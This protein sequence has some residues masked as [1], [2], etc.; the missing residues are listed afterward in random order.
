MKKTLALQIIL[1]NFI[2]SIDYETEIQPIFNSN[3]ISC[4]SYG[5]NSINNH[6]LMLTSYSGLMAGG[7]SGDVIVPGDSTNSILFQQIS[8]LSMPPYGSGSNYLTGYE[9]SLIAQWI[10]EGAL[11]VEELSN[12]NNI[13][14]DEYVLNQPFPNPFNPTTSISFSIPE[15]SQAS[16]KFYDIKGNLISILLNQTMNIGYHQIEWN[17]EELPSGVYFVKMDAGEFTHTQKL[18]LVK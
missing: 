5:S 7:E 10:V 15:Q 16:L 2:F 6:Q 13:Y 3:C 17:A 11:E 4:H 12:S 9:I 8:T 18:M 1:L 14:P